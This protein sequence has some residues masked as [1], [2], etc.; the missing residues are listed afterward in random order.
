MPGQ[1]V[2]SVSF[3]SLLSKHSVDESKMYVPRVV[4]RVLNDKVYFAHAHSCSCFC[5]EILVSDIAAQVNWL[6]R[7]MSK[8]IG[9]LEE[10]DKV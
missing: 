9:K 8:R 3:T 10:V 5:T 1:K 2:T 7:R 4:T 6:E